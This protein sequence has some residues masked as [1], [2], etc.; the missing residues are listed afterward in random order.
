MTIKS[1]Q[2]KIAQAENLRDGKGVTQ[3]G[4]IC[5]ESACP[6]NSRLIA[7]ITLKPGCSIGKHY[8]HGEAEFYCV[9]SGDGLLSDN[10]DICRFS[11]GDSHFCPSGCFHELEN[12]GTQ[13]LRVLAIVITGSAQ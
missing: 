9:L 8:H 4:I 11:E 12:D 6:P 10:G 3:F 7:E 2:K 13:D 5:A 1:N